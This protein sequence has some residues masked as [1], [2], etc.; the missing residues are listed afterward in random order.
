MKWASAQITKRYTHFE[1]WEEVE[2]VENY[3][4]FPELD[5]FISQS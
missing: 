5:S 4:K 3:L 2:I 1:E